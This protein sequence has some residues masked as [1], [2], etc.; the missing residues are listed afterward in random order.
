MVICTK[1]GQQADPRETFCRR[2]GAFL[3]WTGAPAT[4][5]E[6]PPAVAPAATPP[7]RV[8]A[9][10]ELS[11]PPVVATLSAT[12]VRVEPGGQA[13]VTV[14]VRNRA[15]RSTNSLEARPRCGMGDG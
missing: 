11:G 10:P 13:S 1:C 8:N 7:R 14:E 4:P 2:C 5:P 3:E 6:A 15:G 12:S 9:E